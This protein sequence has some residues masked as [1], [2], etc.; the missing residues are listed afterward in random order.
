M[1]VQIYIAVESWREGNQKL[2]IIRDDP[3]SH[4]EILTILINYELY[5]QTH[6][7]LVVEANYEN[8]ENNYYE[9]M[10]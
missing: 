2:S 3:E 5:N 1:E 8:Y 4:P 7:Q 9:T 6:L 10:K